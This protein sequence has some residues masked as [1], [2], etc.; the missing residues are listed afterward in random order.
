[1]DIFLHQLEN[2]F[3]Y[4]NLSVGNIKYDIAV[5][6]EESLI[7]RA[8]VF[9]AVHNSTQQKSSMFHKTLAKYM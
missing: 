9:L 8:G 3:T 1:M 5:L 4:V 2:E 6:L 7:T